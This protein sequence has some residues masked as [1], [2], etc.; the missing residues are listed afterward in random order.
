M[1]TVKNASSPGGTGSKGHIGKGKEDT[2]YA[3]K[4]N[5]WESAEDMAGSV[6]K[7]LLFGLQPV[8]RINM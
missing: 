6:L 1:L 5:T 4:A 8:D 2:G 3:Q 7:A